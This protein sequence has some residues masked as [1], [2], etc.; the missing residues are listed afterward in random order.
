MVVVDGFSYWRM[1][2]L[3][4]GGD[5]LT[6]DKRVYRTFDALVGESTNARTVVRR[7]DWSHSTGRRDRAINWSVY[8]ASMPK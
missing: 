2:A 5:A 7:K 8:G 3:V 1:D 4:D 6:D